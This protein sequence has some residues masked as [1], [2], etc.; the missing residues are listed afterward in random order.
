MRHSAD[1][2]RRRNYM[3]RRSADTTRG[4]AHTMRLRAHM[5]RRRANGIRRPAD[6]TRLPPDVIRR[7]IH[8]A[9]RPAHATRRQSRMR[10]L[11]CDL[12]RRLRNSTHSQDQNA[13]TPSRLRLPCELR[14][15]LPASFADLPSRRFVPTHRTTWARRCGCAGGT[16]ISH[17]HAQAFHTPPTP[18]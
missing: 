7:R 5:T 17:R 16:P 6:I 13:L 1:M 4:A 3:T 9:R 12:P 18:A 8:I 10:R 15:L 14:P 2:S 11:T